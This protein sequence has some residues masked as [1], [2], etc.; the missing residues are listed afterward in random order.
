MAR[1]GEADDERAE[2]EHDEIEHES[3]TAFVLGEPGSG[4]ESSRKSSLAMSA[5]AISSP[6][7]L[8]TSPELAPRLTSK[9][10]FD[11]SGS[12]TN[13]GLGL[14]GQHEE[15]TPSATTDDSIAHL[16]RRLAA[17]SFS[18]AA[19]DTSQSL[20]SLHCTSTRPPLRCK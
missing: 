17:F 15:A 6:E 8:D 18:G 9:R 12:L 13:A 2:G 11:A 20:R 14:F 7:T 3:V 19:V 16:H 10:L 5:N 1:R 4:G